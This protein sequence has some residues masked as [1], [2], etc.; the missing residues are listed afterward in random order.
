M[1]RNKLAQK[2]AI[3][4]QIA[5]VV[6]DDWSR[7]RGDVL[8][9]LRLARLIAFDLNDQFIAG[10]AGFEREADA[11]R[12]LDEMRLRFEEF[13]LSRH[14]EKTRLIEFGRY[15][16]QNRKRRGL[17]KSETF[18]FLGFTHV[19]ARTRQGGFMLNCKSR[20]DRLRAKLKQVKKELGRRMHHAIPK[21][22]EWLCRVVSGFFQYHAVPTNGGALSTF[23]NHV[24]DIWRRVLRRRSQKDG[25]AWRR[26]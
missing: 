19:C 16:A 12:F 1:R 7:R 25:T 14:P 9:A 21:Q 3:S 11:R 6:D 17:G 18:N 8:A 2:M 26:W 24:L 13:G 4:R 10:L 22:G 5:A 15:A 23:R 20:S